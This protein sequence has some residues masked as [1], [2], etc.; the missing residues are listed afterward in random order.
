MVESFD[1]GDDDRAKESRLRTLDLLGQGAAALSRTNYTPGH[2]TASGVVL[3]TAGTEVLLVFH[4]KLRRWLQPGGH[5]EPGDGS[6]SEAAARE[7]REETGA[8]LHS[9]AP[10]LVGIDVHQIP[11][12]DREPAHLHHDIV[13][14]FVADPANGGPPTEADPLLWC[15]IRALI[16]QGVDSAL[17]R[18]VD[19]SLGSP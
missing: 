5:V 3:S 17:L 4:R 14:R 2:I 16:K 19:R 6:V 9:G 11:A 7:V 13:W 10:R 12:N 18:A 1:P 8:L 15:P